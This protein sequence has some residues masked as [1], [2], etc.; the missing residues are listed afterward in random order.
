MQ[1]YTEQIYAIIKDI[2]F[3]R[4]QVKNGIG[5]KELKDELEFI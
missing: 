3:Y 2:S 4:I 5:G 1:S